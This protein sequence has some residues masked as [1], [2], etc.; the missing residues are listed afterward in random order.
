MV[1]EEI[2]G[3]NALVQ[4]WNNALQRGRVPHALLLSE[5]GGYGALKLAWHFA[6]DLLASTLKSPE[7]KERCRMRC[8]KAEHP[9]LHFIFPVATT[10]Q[11]KSH[12]RSELFL[13]PWRQFILQQPYSS[14]NQWYKHVGLEK[15][16]GLINVEEAEDLIKKMAFK[17]FEGGA[18]VVVVWEAHK[19]NTPAAN[20]LLKLIEEPPDGTYLLLVSSEPEQLLQTIYSRCQHLRLSPLS[21]K[22]IETALLNNQASPDQALHLAQQSHGDLAKAL[23]MQGDGGELQAFEQWFVDWV[24]TAFRAKGNKAVVEN[25][26]DW[27][28]ELAGLGREQQKQ[29]LSYCSQQFRLALMLNYGLPVQ[30]PSFAATQFKF[31]KFAPFVHE[32]NIEE[33]REELEKAQYHIE[34]NVSAKMVFGDL[35]LALTRLIHRKPLTP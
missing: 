6:T 21:E 24:R 23:E 33:L 8:R 18:K 20:K 16:Q 7:E 15:K 19:M 34:R 31:E 14:L 13:E 35:A 10:D 12:P 26:L 22:E 9:D 28:I 1:Q 5:A 27:S 11:V 2:L 25:L 3:Q 4:Q 32:N 29:F 30:T 17:A